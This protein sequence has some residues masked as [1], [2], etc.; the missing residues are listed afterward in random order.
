MR[1]AYWT[2][3][4]PVFDAHT[5]VTED[6]ELPG[7]GWGS[8]RSLAQMA[9]ELVKRGHHVEI[10]CWR[11]RPLPVMDAKDFDI[12]IVQRYL[13]YWL[14]EECKSIPTVF[15]QHDVRPLTGYENSII[16]DDGKQTYANFV[17]SGLCT[18][19]VT[20]T[21]SHT[22]GMMQHYNIPHHHFKEI[23]HGLP[24]PK[25]DTSGIEKVKNRMVWISGWNRGLCSA[26]EV[27]NKIDPEKHGKISFH[28]YGHQAEH[29]GNEN[30][31]YPGRTFQ[32]FDWR[33]PSLRQLV[34]ESPHDI[35][36]FGYVSD[37]EIEKAWAECD[38]LLY[39]TDFVETYCICALEAQRAGCFIIASELGSM[40]H[41]IGD[42]GVL[43][44]KRGAEGVDMEHNAYISVVAR[45]LETY[46]DNP[47][48]TIP[49]REAGKAWA[50]EQTLENKAD[51]WEAFLE[52]VIQQDAEQ[53]S[54][55]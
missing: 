25:V 5:V 9:V 32:F 28:I 33:T 22:Y 46:M 47:E 50:K 2:G 51:E 30:A 29:E 16:Y 27:I 55:D 24:E 49:Y 8:E 19:S 14:Y 10:F 38:I 7:G 36:M 43:I 41:T 35:E 39:P 4:S 21:P 40:P 23:G 42:R 3:Y 45:T 52:S 13:N 53:K 26:L 12:V 20:L 18:R 31:P 44:P 15:W 48:L 1:I 34:E 6:W 54:R 11:Q 37:E 17:E